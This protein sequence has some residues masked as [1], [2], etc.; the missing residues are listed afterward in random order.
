MRVLFE[1]LVESFSRTLDSIEM[2]A[3]AATSLYYPSLGIKRFSVFSLC[4][5]IGTGFPES[6]GCPIPGGA[7]GRGWG[8]G[9]PGLK[10]G[11]NRMV[12]KVL[13][14]PAIL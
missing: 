3:K 1:R 6:C 2:S 9:Q 11:W 7:Q 8:F 13:S 14:N 12:C 4:H 10:G 5:Y